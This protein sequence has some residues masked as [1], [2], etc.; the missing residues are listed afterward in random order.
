MQETHFD[1]LERQGMQKILVQ[2]LQVKLGSLPEAAADKIRTIESRDELIELAK[3]VV[4][5][6]SL[7]ELGLD[8]A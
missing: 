1:K 7:A 5:A 3:K 4:T 2:Q 6:S 8:G